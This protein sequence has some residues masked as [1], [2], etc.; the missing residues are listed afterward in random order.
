MDTNEFLLL[1][2]A[3]LDEAKSKELLNEDID[4]LSNKLNHLK[5]QAEIDEK[6]ITGLA[7]EIE[8]LIGQKIIIPNIGIDTN[9]LSKTGKQVGEVIAKSAQDAIRKVSSKGIG[10]KFIVT[11]ESSKAFKKEMKSLVDQWTGNK[12]KLTD[13]NIKTK[14]VFDEEAQKNVE[15]LHRATVKY[16]N[17]LGEVI[18]KTI[19][20]GKIGTDADGN[21]ING[22]VEVA[23]QY[24]KSIDNISKKTSS[25]AN[26]QKQTI[27]NLTNQI[28]QMNRSASDPNASQPI[29][30]KEH[31]DALSKSYQEIISELNRMKSLEGDTFVDAQIHVKELISNFK[32]MVSEFKKAETVSIKM[33]GSDFSSALQTTKNNLEKLKADAKEFPQMVDTIQELD[34]Q[35]STVGDKS[36]LNEVV[37]KLRVA[38][39]ELDK[40]KAESSAS[41]RAERVGIKVSGLQNNIANLQRISPEINNFKTNINDAEVSIESLLADLTKVATQPDFS[42]VNERWN[43]FVKAAKAAGITVTE[44]GTKSDTSAAKIEKINNNLSENKYDAKL[45]S[46]ISSYERLGLETDDVRQRTDSVRTALNELKNAS[47]DELIQKEE[48]FNHEL[49]K[50]HNEMTILKT[51]MESIYNPGRQMR[52]TNEVENWLIKNTRAAKDAREELEKYLNQLKSGKTSVATLDHISERLKTIDTEQRGMRK[53]GKNLRDQFSQAAQ[54]FSQWLSIS[55]AIMLVVSRMRDAVNELKEVNTYLTEISK[56]NETLSKEQLNQI[57][58]DSFDIASKYGKSA[59]N[60]LSAVQETSRAGY[61]NATGI[62][63]LSVAA[64]GAGDMTQELANQMIIATDKAY[65]MDGSVE[66]LKAVLDGMNYITNHN[67]VNMTELSEGMSI[68]GST[69]ASFGVDVNELAA[70]LGTMAATTQQSGS[71]VA[72]A[73]RAILLNVRQVSDEEEGID[74]KGL[75]KYETACNALGVKLKETRDGV[76]SLR[77]PMKVLKELSEEYVKLDKGDIRRTNLLNS[78][79]GKLRSTQLDALLRQWPMYEKMLKEYENGTGSMAVEAEKTANS[80]EGSLNRLS[81]TF[82][83]TI[84]N[85]A[86]SDAIITLINGFNGLLNVVN[87]LTDSFG[88]V[89]SLGSITGLIFG[90]KNVGTDKMYSVIVF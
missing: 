42:T 85:I 40:I 79:G 46:L 55:S 6:S 57:G 21:D 26:K 41:N 59:T 51:D 10:S 39:S 32:S 90:A 87:N 52:L 81:N 67:A 73:F 34:N 4:A 83:D 9:Q 43:A 56:A 30:D 13:V 72:R 71:E 84:G 18:K 70:A 49:N 45:Q 88:S 69:A 20:L 44:L 1:L 66:K 53:L 68:V 29:K 61:E 5:L 22:F 27:A 23:S 24:S 64:Q 15:A 58:N 80:W 47:V 48:K 37:D 11:D 19:A 33:R 86:N 65:K 35:L 82:T 63:E 62:A 36:S 31:V 60:F 17:E 12:G 78:V 75:T 7:K 14:T 76:M 25:L 54:D 89:G 77:D 74:A 38:K 8:K 3:K 16:E 28:N 2:Q 50:S